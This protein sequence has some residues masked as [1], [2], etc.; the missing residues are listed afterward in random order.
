MS[1]SNS[2]SE[3]T[4][5]NIDNRAVLGQGALFARDGSTIITSSI[6]PGAFALAGKVVDQVPV[7]VNAN[8]AA[9]K[10]VLDF[11]RQTSD[12]ATQA[13]STAI[14]QAGQ[15]ARDAYADAKGTGASS[16]LMMALIVAGAIVAVVA[17]G[18][19]K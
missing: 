4:T 8:G 15:F 13:S 19:I 10:T 16:Q 17:F 14:N 18:K 7:L 1:D 5:Q 9:L 2:S 11:A 6:D 12:T 3:Q